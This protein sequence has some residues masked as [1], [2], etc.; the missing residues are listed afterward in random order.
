M[1]E[2]DQ[3]AGRGK[4]VSEKSLELNVC[5]E[6]LQ[7]IRA[8]PGCEGALWL[9]LTQRQERRTGLDEFIHNVGPGVALM[10]QFKAPWRTSVADDLYKFSINERQHEA[11][12]DLAS[13]YPQAVHYV[14]PF[15]SKWSKA[16]QYAPDLV[17]DTWFVPASS[18]PLAELL[19]ASTPKTGRHRVELERTGSGIVV[20]AHSPRVVGEAINAGEFL[21]GLG[22]S[23][24][25]VVSRPLVPQGRL[26][27]WTRAWDDEGRPVGLTSDELAR[28][29]AVRGRGVRFT[30]LSAL[31]IPS[32]PIDA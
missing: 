28:T 29:A 16:R 2:P 8:V 21:A 19:A 15:F 10:L 4:E 26:R 7:R 17:Q 20:T 13:H 5:A 1:L 22:Q 30:G 32:S 31:Y 12:E 11:L 23:T 27:D 14:F 18:L 3:V 25:G 24:S 9:G 6:L